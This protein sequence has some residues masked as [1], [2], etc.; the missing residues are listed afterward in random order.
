MKFLVIGG[1]GLIG[2]KAVARLRAAGHEALA[3]APSTGVDILTGAGLDAAMAGADCVIDLSNS[4]SFE[5]AAVLE[6]FATAGRTILAA[7]ARAGVGHHLALSVVGTHKLAQSGY[8]RAKIEQERLIRESGRPYTIVHSTQFFEF[9]PGIVQSGAD[10]ER[11]RLPQALIQPI[12]AEDVAAAVARLAQQAP[13]NGIVEIAGPERLPLASLA[14]RY[15]R[16]VDDPRVAVADPHARYFGAE[17][18]DATL[19]PDG[20]AWL[21]AMDFDAWLAQSG[22]ARPA[23][24][25]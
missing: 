25:A 6:F 22:P 15:L 14:Q 17:L 10:G 23:P 2:G 21:G 4:P 7:E 12:A 1:T 13:A 8:F 24:R 20:E 9:L 11:V 16:A 5:D 18:D 3:A 19:V